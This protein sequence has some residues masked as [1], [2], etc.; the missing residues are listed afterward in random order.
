MLLFFKNLF[1]LKLK[2]F[3][4]LK[5]NFIFC[6]IRI[7]IFNYIIIKE[8]TVFFFKMLRVNKFKCYCCF[9]NIVCFIRFGINIIVGLDDFIY[10]E[11][12]K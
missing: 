2:L 8:S 7:S 12:S 1:F 5:F 6:N 9:K 11:N 3:S 4:F 10:F